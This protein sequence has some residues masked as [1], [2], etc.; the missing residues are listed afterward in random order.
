M[1][2]LTRGVCVLPSRQVDPL[3]D[4]EIR[5]H[6]ESPKDRRAADPEPSV[7]GVVREIGGSEVTLT[8]RDQL[9]HG[10]PRPGQPI[11]GIRDGGNRGPWISHG[12][13]ILSISCASLGPL[14]ARVGRR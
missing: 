14:A 12:Q 10:A 9:G 3:D 4:A 2:G 7:T 5:Q 8:S 13:M 1:S 11:P 6:V